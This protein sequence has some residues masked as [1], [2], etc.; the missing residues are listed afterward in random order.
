MAVQ[1]TKTVTNAPR[2]VQA[3]QISTVGPVNPSTKQRLLILSS[4]MQVALSELQ[5]MTNFPAVGD[6][7]VIPSEGYPYCAPRSTFLQSYT[8]SS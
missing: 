3:F 1:P 5:A 6:Y 4:G 2:F 7:Y 8:V